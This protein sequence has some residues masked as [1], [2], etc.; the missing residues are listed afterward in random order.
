MFQIGNKSYTAE[1]LEVLS[2]AGVLQIGEKNNPQGSTAN[3]SPLNG[4][5]QGATPTQNGMYS[6]AGGRQGVFS[7]LTRPDSWLSIVNIQKSE[8]ATEILD[9]QT[10]Q[11][12]DGT[13]NATNFCGN[14][15]EP[16]VLKTARQT[17]VWGSFYGKTRLNSP[18]QMGQLKDRGDQARNVLNAPAVN[19][20]F[21]PDIM[22]RLTD[23][24]S[25]LANELY[26]FGNALERSTEIVSISGTAL[27]DNSRFGWFQE[28]KGLDGLIK[29]G[30]TDSVTGLAAAALDSIV[31]PFNA[32]IT[33]T[34]AG[35]DGRTFTEVL[36]DTMYALE[37]RA[38]QV[39]MGGAVQYAIVMRQ[40]MFRKAVEVQANKYWFYKQ[41]GSQYGEINGQVTELQQ[42]RLD[43]LNNQYLLI[44]GQAYP[45][46]FTEGAEFTALGSGNYKSD[47]Y[48]VPVSW[49]G[50]PLLRLQYFD[51][52]NQYTSEFINFMGNT[53]IKTINN[54]MMLVGQRDLGLCLEFHFQ[55]RMRL[56]L[57]TPWLAARVDDVSFSYTNVATRTALPG[58]SLYVNGGVSYR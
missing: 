21:I 51:M 45:V 49:G 58:T 38:R 8:F 24:R 1:E 6:L 43:M 23:T 42:L 31:V 40:E 28:F 30:H 5:F 13:T 50:V 29:T 15:P 54:G 34:A 41:P 10:G 55:A 12:A 48:I 46:V 4:P 22:Q 37:D 39:G 36:D 19:N 33:S 7:A 25:Q 44:K 47:M 56:I 20:P 2:K 53:N 52:S 35:G 17:Y 14:P 11:T 16:G 27:A 3:A 9:T 57:D 26:T 32:A 18:A